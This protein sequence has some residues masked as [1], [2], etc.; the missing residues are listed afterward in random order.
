[1]THPQAVELAGRINGRPLAHLGHAWV[2]T[3]TGADDS[4]VSVR[5]HIGMETEVTSFPV[6]YESYLF[7]LAE[8]LYA[9]TGAVFPLRRD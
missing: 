5:N 6:D 8:C 1:M 4:S 9:G 3:G 2:N 7:A